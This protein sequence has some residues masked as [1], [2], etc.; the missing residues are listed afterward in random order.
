MLLFP[1]HL[2]KHAGCKNCL[3]LRN[4]NL[5]WGPAGFSQGP[6]WQQRRTNDWQK[7]KR[8]LSG[9][10]RGGIKVESVLG[11]ENMFQILFR[12]QFYPHGLL[13]GVSGTQTPLPHP[14][15]RA[16]P[17]PHILQILT[18]PSSAFLLTSWVWFLLLVLSLW[19]PFSPLTPS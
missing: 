10:S 4:W 13:L 14:Y 8:Y 2:K 11:Q 3:P 16:L 12:C 7:R 19:K 6:T 5:I 15:P 18:V 9:L 1:F 17:L